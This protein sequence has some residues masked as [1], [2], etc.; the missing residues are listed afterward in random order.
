MANRIEMKEVC[1][2]NQLYSTNRVGEGQGQEG[3]GMEEIQ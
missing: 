2:L 3:L 1:V